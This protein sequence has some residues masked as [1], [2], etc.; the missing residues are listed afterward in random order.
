MSEE[1]IVDNCLCKGEFVSEVDENKT[2]GNSC[3]SH[4]GMCSSGG[5]A[6]LILNIDTRWEWLMS[7]CIDIS[8]EKKPLLLIE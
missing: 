6:P 7:C 1:S 5:T 8:Q 2:K 4:E 3:A